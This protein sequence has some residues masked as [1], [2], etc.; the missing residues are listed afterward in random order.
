MRKKYLVLAVSVVSAVIVL[1]GL[2]A[3]RMYEV[4]NE[5][6]IAL[7]APT[8]ELKSVNPEVWDLSKLRGF[9]YKDGVGISQAVVGSVKVTWKS[10]FNAGK[11]DIS[12][13]DESGSKVVKVLKKN[14]TIQTKGV[15]ILATIFKDLPKGKYLLEL[16]ATRNADK[17]TVKSN[18]VP[19]EITGKWGTPAVLV[20]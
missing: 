17:S 12:L 5:A 16:T 2:E 14:I 19:V 8:L 4:P 18:R 3:A 11:V 13:L 20:R 7:S 10:N 1:A 9:I 6:A 15:T